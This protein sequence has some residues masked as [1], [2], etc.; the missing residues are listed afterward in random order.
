[1]DRPDAKRIQIKDW[2]K[3]ELGA[4]VLNKE[5]VLWP[6]GIMDLRDLFWSA[7]WRDAG[8]KIE[9]L[10]VAGAPHRGGARFVADSLS[11]AAD[12]PFDTT[13]RRDLIRSLPNCKALTS[14]DMSRTICAWTPH[15]RRHRAK[16]CASQARVCP[17]RTLSSSCAR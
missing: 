11:F 6:Y 16:C 10:A 13:C 2:K 12:I 3:V 1:M 8:G 15:W 9:S 14:V 5:K 4:I 17:R 7:L